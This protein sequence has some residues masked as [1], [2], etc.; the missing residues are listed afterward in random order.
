MTKCHCTEHTVYVWSS[1]FGTGLRLRIQYRNTE[2]S[3]IKCRGLAYQTPLTGP[4]K[5]KRGFPFGP[6]PVFLFYLQI[7]GQLVL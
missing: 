1:S 4:G 5:L 6:F 2:V 3:F 7:Q